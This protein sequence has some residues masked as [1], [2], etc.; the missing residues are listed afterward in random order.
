MTEKELRVIL[1][2][3]LKRY[4]KFR[5]ITQAEFAEKV[6]ISIPA[7]YTPRLKQPWKV[8][9]TATSKIWKIENKP[10]GTRRERGNRLAP[11]N[12][13]YLGRM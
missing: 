6:D 11:P 8:C 1:S 5:K 10:H 2:I 4:R 13:K 3:N 9:K 12:L 7:T